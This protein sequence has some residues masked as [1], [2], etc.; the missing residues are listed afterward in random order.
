ML[1]LLLLCFSGLTGLSQNIRIKSFDD[2][3]IALKNGDRIRV[4]IHFAQCR[5]SSGK[6]GQSP[7]PDVITGMDIDIYEYFAPGAAHN[8][9]AFMVFGNSKLIQ[10]PLGKGFVYNYGKVRIN[11]D[12]TVLITA[13]Y[14]NP[15][16]FRVLM[17]ESFIGKLNDGSNN[18]GI[19][20]F[21]L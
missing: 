3:M 20:L 16:S 8:E 5:W 19:H 13:R 12:N 7:V 15:K 11:G 18:E 9:T 10:N 1:I 6:A 14:I 2:L 17:D 4:V 21:K